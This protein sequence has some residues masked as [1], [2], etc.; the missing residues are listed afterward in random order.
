[1]GLD[2]RGGRRAADDK[3]AG[4]NPYHIEADYMDDLGYDRFDLGRRY[5]LSIYLCTLY[6]EKQIRRG[7]D[8]NLIAQQTRGE[9]IAENR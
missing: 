5:G 4:A 1:M 2:N 9:A 8:V 7:R 6:H 3:E